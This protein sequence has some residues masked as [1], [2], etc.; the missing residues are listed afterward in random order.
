MHLNALIC[1]G[2]RLIGVVKCLFIYIFFI[3]V[4]KPTIDLEINFPGMNKKFKII[5]NLLILSEN[6]NGLLIKNVTQPKLS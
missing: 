6:R 4:K 2:Y 1:F 3:C 5:R